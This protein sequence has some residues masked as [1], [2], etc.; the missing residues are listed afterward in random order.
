LDHPYIP[1]SRDDKL[2]KY[3]DD[4]NLLVP[5]TSNCTLSEEFEHIKNWALANKMVINM[6]KTEELVFYRPATPK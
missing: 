2:I 3:A 1:K 4:T 6:S 5:E